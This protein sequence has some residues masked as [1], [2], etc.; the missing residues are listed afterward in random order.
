MR[1]KEGVDGAGA[2]EDAVQKE[3]ADKL[4]SCAGDFGPLAGTEQSATKSG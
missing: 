3:T 2:M 4:L 1:L